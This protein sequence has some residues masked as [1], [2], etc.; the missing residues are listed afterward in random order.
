M[1]ADDVPD[2]VAFGDFN[3]CY[4]RAIGWAIDGQFAVALIDTNRDGRE[5]ALEVFEQSGDRWRLIDSMDDVGDGRGEGWSVESVVWIYGHDAPDTR[6]QIAH[7]GQC[8]EL[9]V[10]ETGW[11]AFIRR[12]P[13]AD[14][15]RV[16]RR[17]G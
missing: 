2:W 5:I 4:A 15:T 12:V 16:P 7:A 14:S 10:G 1:N 6:V 3:V 11:W 8:H 13:D 17:V 9:T